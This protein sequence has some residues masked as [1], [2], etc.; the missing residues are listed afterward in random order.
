VYCKVL[1]VV[2]HQELSYSWK[3]KG[4]D[5]ELNVDS[6]V[7][8]T[9]T[10]KDGGTEL[11]IRHGDFKVIDTLMFNAMNEGWLENIEKIEKLTK[12]AVK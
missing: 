1:K 4:P 5:G 11:V 3:C 7:T 12:V 8:W 10:P 6:I 2:S 9:L